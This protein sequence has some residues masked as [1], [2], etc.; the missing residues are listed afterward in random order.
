MRQYTAS[1][2]RF[3]KMEMQ[4]LQRAEQEL[5]QLEEEEV[6]VHDVP[7]ELNQVEAEARLV[8]V[9]STMLVWMTEIFACQDKRAWLE[10]TK[11]AIAPPEWEHEWQD[12]EARLKELSRKQSE[13]RAEAT[14][15]KKQLN[16]AEVDVVAI[17]QEIKSI[18]A[19][20]D[21]Q[22][23]LLSTRS[24]SDDTRKNLEQQMHEMEGKIEQ[25][26]S[27]IQ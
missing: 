3:V 9:E 22:R 20:C 10:T 17:Q 8:E 2:D 11:A 1:S 21:R 18:Q 6:E 7:L 26:K 19:V 16:K 14:Q 12:N 23:V 13:L 24:L 25:L 15:L 5:K 4:H 27:S